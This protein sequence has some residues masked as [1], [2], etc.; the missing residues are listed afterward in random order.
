MSHGGQSSFEHGDDG[1]SNPPAPRYKV[2]DPE[3]I[4]DLMRSIRQS[5]LDRRVR[6]AWWR[7]AR[8][9]FAAATLICLSLF[10]AGVRIL[11]VE[12]VK[13]ICQQQ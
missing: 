9:G 13:W 3:G 1:F 4:Q 10:A 5:E 7:G 2:L 12:G 6:G 11:G 8:A